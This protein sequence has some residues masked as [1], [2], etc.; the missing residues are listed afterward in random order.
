[1]IYSIC[2]FLNFTPM[3]KT[4]LGLSLMGMALMLAG[5]GQRVANQ[6]NAPAS[7]EQPA[8]QSEQNNNPVISSL[9]DAMDFGKQMKCTYDTTV[10]GSTVEMT[11]NVEGKKFRSIT[12]MNGKN[13]NSLFDGTTMYTWTDGQTT[14][15][16]ITMAC[17]SDLKASLPQG[18]SSAPAVQS[19]EDQ[20]KSAT[21]VSC[22][23]AEDADFSVPTTVTFTDECAMLKNSAGMMKNLPQGATPNGTVPNIPN[24]P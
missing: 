23:P 11:A 6:Q 18:Q 7:N 14:G 1:M 20:F 9:K 5:C 19:P 17:I 3:R 10:N 4:L 21:N 12:D 8:A 22:V 13:V 16:Q 2:N 24:T 15:M